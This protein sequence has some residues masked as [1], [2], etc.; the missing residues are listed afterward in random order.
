MTFLLLPLLLIVLISL[1]GLVVLWIFALRS[2]KGG[3]PA[4][5][6]CGYPVTGTMRLHCAECGADFREVG[7]TTP[8]TRR[9]MRWWVFALGWT[10][11]LP[12]P[13]LF[14]VGI[15]TSLGP[16]TQNC[17]ERVAITAT[18]IPGLTGRL[19]VGGSSTSWSAS[20]NVSGNPGSNAPAARSG[21]VI[22]LQRISQPAAINS[23]QFD[24]QYN[25]AVG[26]QQST[27]LKVSRSLP[28]SSYEHAL[29]HIRVP[30]S[31]DKT[32]AAQGLAALATQVYAGNT[33]MQT[34]A[35][36]AG[37][38]RGSSSS[39]RPAM[40]FLIALLLGGVLVYIGGFGLFFLIKHNRTRRAQETMANIP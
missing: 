30:N 1:A 19:I 28:L 8:M 35:W 7:I 36:K 15:L 11:C 22:M 39:S 18:Q 32:A 4:C 20:R 5:G 40:W 12:M 27:I 34:P 29:Q 10:L 24:L 23:V 6:R 21:N 3:L 14:V 33:T 13:V 37:N 9:G 26:P 25:P 16:T 31:P 38:S 17:K 2:P